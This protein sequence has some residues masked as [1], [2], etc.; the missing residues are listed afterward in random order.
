MTHKSGAIYHIKIITQS[1]ISSTIFQK[2]KNVVKIND[3]QVPV[4]ASINDA[5]VPVNVSINDAHVPVY[6]SI[7][8]AHVPVNVSINDAQVP[9]YASAKINYD[10]NCHLDTIYNINIIKHTLF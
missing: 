1:F 5:H 8:D 7:N 9:V 2:R 10:S 3:A 6:V 4:Y